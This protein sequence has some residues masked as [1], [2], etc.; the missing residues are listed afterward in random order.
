MVEYN[1]KVQ[2][3]ARQAG[4]SEREFTGEEKAVILNA[5]MLRSVA[6]APIGGV[7]D[8]PIEKREFEELILMVLQ[9]EFIGLLKDSGLSQTAKVKPLHV[10]KSSTVDGKVVFNQEIVEFSNGIRDGL[11][12]LLITIDSELKV[13]SDDGLRLD[14]YRKKFDAEVLMKAVERA[15]KT[16]QT[17]AFWT[18]DQNADPNRPFFVPF[19][20]IQ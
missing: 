1:L 3:P 2:C 15:I 13:A 14:L 11:A 19:V 16:L 10:R 4:R 6:D 20:L 17:E 9:K 8:F 5:K 18:T 12:K 7:R